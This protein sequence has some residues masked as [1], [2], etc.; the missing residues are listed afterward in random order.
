MLWRVTPQSVSCVVY[1]E[2]LGLLCVQFTSDFQ[3]SSEIRRRDGSES[4]EE[5]T[6]KERGLSNARADTDGRDSQRHSEGSMDP[7][8]V[9]WR[10]RLRG[11]LLWYMK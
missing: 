4:S 2:W 9:D 3:I 11:G 7:R 8:Q 10:R 6:E 5:G 1:V